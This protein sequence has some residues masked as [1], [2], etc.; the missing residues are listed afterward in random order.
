MTTAATAQERLAQ[1]GL[2]LPAPPPAV[3]AFQPYV[4]V[5][6]T[7]YTSGQIALPL[8]PPVEIEA[9]AELGA[10]AAGAKPRHP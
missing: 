6:T 5:G 7:I 2:T 4:R 10:T 9:I 8:G 3:A 1:L